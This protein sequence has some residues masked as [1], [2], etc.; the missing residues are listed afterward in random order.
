MGKVL[1]A[2]VML[3]KRFVSGWVKVN[4]RHGQEEMGYGFLFLLMIWYTIVILILFFDGENKVKSQPNKCA[5]S[6]YSTPNQKYLKQSH[7]SRNNLLVGLSLWNFLFLYQTLIKVVNAWNWTI[8]KDINFFNCFY[9]Y[10]V[11]Q[12]QVVAWLW[13]F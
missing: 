5:I 7:N 13:I 1:P 6:I 2:A 9:F 11:E 8:G 10:S 3:T 4:Y 12:Q